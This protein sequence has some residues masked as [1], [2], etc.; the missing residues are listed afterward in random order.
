[1]HMTKNLH[2]AQ[3]QSF[4]WSACVVLVTAFAALDTVLGGFLRE[5]VAIATA[6][7][8]AIFSLAI[9]TVGAYASDAPPGFKFIRAYSRHKL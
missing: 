9:V 8:V 7:Y 2:E 6:E 4:F 3:N 1:M 5:S